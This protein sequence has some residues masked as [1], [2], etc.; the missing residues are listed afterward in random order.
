MKEI[1]ELLQSLGVAPRSKEKKKTPSVPDRSERFR[2]LT[3]G[4]KKETKRTYRSIINHFIR[5]AGGQEPDE[6]AVRRFLEH[7]ENNGY[8]RNYQRV[9]WYALKKYFEVLGIPWKLKNSEYPE[10][11]RGELKEKTKKLTFS[12]RQVAK[13]IQATKQSGCREE[14]M[15]LALASTYGF[16]RVEICSLR[17]ENIDRDTHQLWAQARKRGERR[18][19]IIP[20]AIRP[21]IYPWNFEKRIAPPTATKIFDRILAKTGIKKIKGMSIHALRRALITQLSST[22]IP[23]MR[24][25]SFVGWRRKQM[26]MLTEYDNPDFKERDPAVFSRHPFLSIWK[27]E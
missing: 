26:G 4:Q 3:R 11:D 8:S 10:L 2:L 25:Y 18:Y 13:M 22:D 24:V 17:E 20:E 6:W 21:F 19:H 27:E 12:K 9:C 5:T 23:P 16:R 14:K 15:L 7:L 1:D